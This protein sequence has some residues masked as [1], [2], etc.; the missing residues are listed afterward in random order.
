[1]DKDAMTD[2]I[3]LFVGQFTENDATPIPVGVSFAGNYYQR[4]L[5]SVVNIEHSLSLIYSEDR[6]AYVS[7]HDLEY[8]HLRQDKIVFN[9]YSVLKHLRLISRNR[10]RIKKVLF[11]NL[12]FYSLFFYYYLVLFRTTKIVVLLADAGFIVEKN[13]KSRILRYSLKYASGFLALRDFPELRKFKVK[14]EV[15]PGIVTDTQVDFQSPRISNT[16]LLSGSL[17]VTMGLLLAL[18]FFSKQ[19]DLKLIISGMPYLMSDAELQEIIR[20]Y[21]CE[22]IRFLGALDYSEYVKILNTTEFS[23]NLRN[24]VDIEHNY[25]FPSKILEYMASGLI[26]ISTVKYPELPDALYYYT[27]YSVSGL[28]DC[29]HKILDMNIEHKVSN[30]TNAY[31]YVINHLS[32]DVLKSKIFGLYY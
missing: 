18:E 16:V 14:I 23:L 4:K 27:E 30:K 3:D 25:N 7:N 2:K 32:G 19:K 5:R 26:V 28:N 29:F 12:N 8:V 1:M 13:F 20:K 21:N 10:K 9:L 24:P 22:Q 15:M 17:G 31:N 6:N 11:F